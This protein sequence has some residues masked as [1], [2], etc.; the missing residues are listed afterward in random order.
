MEV[1]DGVDF[2]MEIQFDNDTDDTG[3]LVK[4]TAT[5][6]EK[7]LASVANAFNSMALVVVN[8]SISTEKDGSKIMDVFSITD[9][10]GQKVPPEE[11]DTVGD[12]IRTTCKA[13]KSTKSSAPAI[14]GVAAAAEARFLRN[15]AAT[16]APTGGQG[17]S[18]E[19]MRSDDGLINAEEAAAR[20]EAAAALELAAAEMAQAAAALVTVER[21]AAELA[22]QAIADPN[23]ESLIN[24]LNMQEEARVEASAVLERRM[25]AMEAALASRRQLKEALRM[26]QQNA[27]AAPVPVP[28]RSEVMT[29]TQPR[30]IMAPP[31]AP[32]TGP[33]CGQGYEII[34]QGFNWESEKGVSGNTWYQHMFD[35]LDE[36]AESGYTSIWL[37]PPTDSV[38]EQGYLPTD[39]YNLNSRYGSE[40]ELITLL[41]KMREK[42]IKSVADIVINHR[43]A[44][45]QKDGKWNQFGGRLGWDESHI[46]SNNQEWGGTGARSSGEEYEAAPNVDHTQERVRENL[47]E[48]L[49]WMREHIGYDGWRFDYVKGYGG[50]FTG[51]YVNA[52]TP[53]LA[54]GEYWDACDYSDGVL[55]YNQDSHR[56]RTVDWCDRTGGTTGAFDFTTKGIL[57][58]AVGRNELWRLVDAQ[59]RPPGVMGLWPSRAVTFIDN[60]DTG[61][62]LNHWPFPWEHIPAGYAY[63]LTHPGTPCVFIDHWNDDNLRPM[64]QDLINV[65]KKLRVNAR[66]KV[67][68]LVAKDNLY[69]AVIDDKVVMKIGGAD[70][71]P[72]RFKEH[73]L[74]DKR[75]EVCASGNN[76]AVW[77]KGEETNNQ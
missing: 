27:T 26:A 62:T 50:E 54:F 49:K 42:N 23:D 34:L 44:S 14:Y 48:W 43:C 77:R 7:F 17:M 15:N 63:L 5:N 30:E 58:E 64:L 56:Q 65:R 47:K 33:A 46:T 53:K 72:N 32:G 37:P 39:L 76:Y 29:F 12:F 69:A 57:Q 61:S 2:V 31:M 1:D 22:N 6:Q 36:F 68:V 59:G 35:R 20:G 21:A 38:S 75:W 74:G 41:R 71:S 45:Y 51:E 10:N 11:W 55:S 18:L 13:A 70:F 67:K 25:A 8:A 66:S 4:I 52:S 28:E 40:E 19:Q 9:M 3:T 73:D 16:M 24:R 60:H